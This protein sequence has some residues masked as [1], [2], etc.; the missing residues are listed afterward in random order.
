M[1][2]PRLI[3]REDRPHQDGCCPVQLQIYIDRK[4][5]AITLPG[6]AV[7]PADWDQDAGQLRKSHP[8]HQEDSLQLGMALGRAHEILV[9]FRLQGLKISAASFR[10]EFRNN[11]SRQD[12]L[13]YWKAKMETEY[14][15]RVIG[16]ATRV[17]HQRTLSKLQD[18][19]GKVLF[20]EISREWLE[21]WDEHHALLLE[22][23][24]YEGMREREKALK[25]IKKYLN[26]AR[27]DGKKFS[28]PFINFRWPRYSVQPVFL[29]KEEIL[30]LLT[31]FRV[32]YY[33]EESMDRDASKRGLTWYNAEQY[34]S[35]SGIE[36]IRN[37]I[38][39]FL[40]QCF[41]GQRFSDLQKMTHKNIEGAHLV[42]VPEKTRETS[43]KKVR[44]WVTPVMKELML[45]GKGKL[46]P[47]ISNQKY[48]EYLKELARLAEIHKNLTSHVGRHTYAT[49]FLQEGGSI[50]VLQQ[51]MGLSSLKTLMVYVHI[52]E[53]RKDQE[54]AAVWSWCESKEREPD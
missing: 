21:K 30:K 26:A 18:Y 14:N 2:V 53:K 37:T 49:T 41:T 19:A 47:T 10:R 50:E 35:E 20:S 25:Q 43:G 54:Q 33:I 40:W 48:N 12:F 46:V 8:R 32:P 23:A 11:A 4:R 15:R 24:G 39:A 27:Q 7:M 22:K 13:Q 36:R 44:M 16:A 6:V 51:L 28:D 17:S 29:E 9:D 38:R 42:W 5:V 31:W 1:P 3:L 45:E 52:T 34:C